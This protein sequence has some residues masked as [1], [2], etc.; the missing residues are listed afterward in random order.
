MKFFDVFKL[1]KVEKSWVLYDVANS[2]F[3]LIVATTVMPIFFKDVA[4][5]GIDHAVSTANWGFANSLS[6]LIL[7]FMAPVLGTLADYRDMKKK[8]LFFFFF[9]GV[10]GTL[11]LMTIDKGNWLTCLLIYGMARIGFAG[12]N[13]FYDSFLIDVA[14]KKRRDWLSS[15]G[16]G[17]GYI[18]SVIP[19][20]LVIAIVL[21][22]T[23]PGQDSAF[24]P[25]VAKS[26]FFI[27]AVWWII[28][29]VP[30]FKNVRQKYFISPSGQPVRESFSRL[31]QTFVQIRHHRDAF[32]LLL[33]YF[34]YIDGVNTIIIMATAYGRDVGL[35]V[36][37]LILAVLMI[38]VVAFPFA[39][40]YGRLAE[41]FS[42]KKMI[43]AGIGI[44]AIITLIAF[45]LPAFSTP[46]KV[47]TFWLLAF[48]VATS[49]GGI[50]SLSR[51]FYG[52]LIPEERSAEFFGF[53]NIVGKFATIAG[54]FL[55]GF[56]SRFTGESRYGILGIMLLFIVGG[57]IL[58]TVRPVKY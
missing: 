26:A 10:S 54:P 43:F 49:Q 32:L 6:S 27:T 22:Y 46:W 55:V 57:G 14:E 4:S 42:S 15:C 40:L 5:K 8:F 50:Q 21:F 7:A 28:F 31:Y 29:S 35:G 58:A 52:N 20:L 23:A 16:Y 47:R 36:T 13:L 9:L 11:F 48:L 39:L 51:S 41:K 17:W 24:G 33:A 38:Q 37:F 19:F 56:F 45:F 34:F 18:G 1:S 25:N 2:A 53:Y 44:Y 30:L 3:I 12:A